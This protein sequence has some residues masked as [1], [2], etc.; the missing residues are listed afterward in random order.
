M[1]LYLVAIENKTLIPP[2]VGESVD[3][4]YML[5]LSFNLQESWLIDFSSL[6][7]KKYTLHR[8]CQ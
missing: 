5:F 4:F 6:D 2:C 1:V 3:A 7:S 8:A